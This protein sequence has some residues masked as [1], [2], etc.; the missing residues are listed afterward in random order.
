MLNNHIY[1]LIT[2]IHQEHKSLWRIKNEYVK[3]AE[4]CGQCVDFWN[5]LAQDKEEHIKGL[6]EILKAELK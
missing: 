2:Q 5:K 6:L 1:N 4:G 3:D